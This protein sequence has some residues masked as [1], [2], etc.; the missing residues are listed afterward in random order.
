MNEICPT[1]EEFNASFSLDK[2]N[3]IVYLDNKIEY[4]ISMVEL[5]SVP[6]DNVSPI[7]EGFKFGLGTSLLYLYIL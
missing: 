6:K 2:S 7:V 4:F 5:L 3:K 1:Y